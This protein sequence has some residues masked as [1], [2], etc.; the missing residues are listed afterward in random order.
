MTNDELSYKILRHIQQTEQQSPTLTHIQTDFYTQLNTYLNELK[1]IVTQEKDPKKQALYEDEQ[2]NTAKIGQRI[3]ELR[4]KKIVQAALSKVRGAQPNL[5][6]LLDDEKILYTQLVDT[7][8]KN[9]NLIQQ[10]NTPQ[11]EKEKNNHEKPRETVP[12]QAPTNTN[13]NPIIRIIE[14]IPKFVGTDMHTYRLRKND[15]LSLPTD[16]AEILQKRKVATL[17]K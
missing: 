5:D 10:P 6:N 7:I 4:E 11:E 12:T 9:R 16:M 1:K 14:D 8:T 17:V 13:S 15:V 2:K 3:Y